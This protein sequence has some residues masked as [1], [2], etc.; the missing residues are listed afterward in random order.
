M[1]SL[2]LSSTYC[3]TLI[4]KI[5]SF[6]RR[7]QNRFGYPVS[8]LSPWCLRIEASFP[9]FQKTIGSHCS[10]Y[11][12]FTRQRFFN[13]VY[14]PAI[15][16]HPNV[17]P[18]WSLTG[19]VSPWGSAGFFESIERVRFSFVFFCLSISGTF[20]QD[21]LRLIRDVQTGTLMTSSEF[22]KT[23]AQQ[24]SIL[25]R[26]SLQCVVCAALVHLWSKSPC[27]CH[28]HI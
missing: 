4:F 20:A 3:H 2:V 1:T 6:L 9:A 23:C 22:M 17:K 13:Q 15:S 18:K 12:L 26:V 11:M 21:T 7:F 10:Q 25:C 28:L 5:F 14:T 16:N 8:I 27:S 19:E 24:F